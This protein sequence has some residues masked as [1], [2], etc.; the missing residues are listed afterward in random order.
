MALAMFELTGAVGRLN[1]EDDSPDEPLTHR[2][3][4][5]FN[6]MDASV[7]SELDGPVRCPAVTFRFAKAPGSAAWTHLQGPSTTGKRG[8]P[9]GN[10]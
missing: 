10:P 6:L 8:R 3:S 2:P 4:Q 1:L 9:G 7:R 5:A